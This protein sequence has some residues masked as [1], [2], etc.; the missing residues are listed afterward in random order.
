MAQE[1]LLDAQRLARLGDWTLDFATKRF[2]GSDVVNDILGLVRGTP[3]I[4]FED[5]TELVHPLDRER[6]TSARDELFSRTREQLVIEYRILRKDGTTCHV[7][8]RGHA[9]VDID[10]KPLSYTGIMQDITERKLAERMLVLNNRALESASSGIVIVD[11]L[12][13]DMP[14]ISV[15]QAFERLTGYASHE[16]IGRNCRFLQGDQR[17]QGGLADIRA[18]L[19]GKAEGHAVLL[20]YRKD[21]TPFWIDLK[22]APVKDADGA[23]TH[24]IGNQTDVSDGV[25]FE[26]ELAFQ[27]S[28]DALTGLPNR[29]LLEDRLAQV[30]NFANRHACMAGVAFVDLDHFKGINDTLGHNMGDRLLKIAAQR[31][32]S[33]LRD[34]DT[35]SR[36]G[37][38]EFVVI[39]PDIASLSD[40][41]EIIARIYKNLRAP[42]S[43]DGHEIHVDASIGVALYPNDGETAGELLKC[44]DM[45]MYHAKKMGKNNFQ[46]F[47]ADMRK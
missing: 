32:T 29:T 8:V 11:A 35:V 30:L 5:Y 13:P 9:M 43:I 6:L 36:F 2:F 20:N 7:E 33:S 41:E 45:A 15:N 38:D 17:D 1:Q 40:M 46:I 24:F 16:V 14:I 28:H 39:C 25:R 21:G 31:F 23:V 37:G 3:S 10:G 18:A 42:L 44:A 22:I 47:Q 19:A 12:L 4:S 26:K 27:A 34:G